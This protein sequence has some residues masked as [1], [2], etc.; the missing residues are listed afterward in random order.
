[1]ESDRFDALARSLSTTGSRRRTLAFALSGVLAPLFVREDAA[2]HDPSK[3]CK[4]KSGKAKKKCVKQAKAHDAAHASETPPP[5]VPDCRGKDCGPGGCGGS[6]G[7]CGGGSD[8]VNGI[9]VCPSETEMC[10]GTCVTPLCLSGMARNPITCGC[11]A[12]PG[13]DCSGDCCSGRCDTTPE[14]GDFE[15]CRGQREGEPCQFNEQCSSELCT[16]TVCR[17]PS[18]RQPCQGQCYQPC[19]PG[20]TRNPDTCGCVPITT[21]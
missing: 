16:D 20:E 13:Q 6:C 5:C 8:C 21:G 11:C 9:C 4:K 18:N 19:P 12:R 17:C 1:M 2:A 14:P 3:R 10:Q 15:A 7:T